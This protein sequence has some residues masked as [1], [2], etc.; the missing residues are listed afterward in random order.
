MTMRPGPSAAR[1]VLLPGMGATAAMYNALRRRLDFPIECIDWPAYR[2]ERSYAEV[3][4]RIV[5]EHDIRDGDV[6]GGSSLG[7]MVA[8]EMAGIVRPA[9]CVLLGSAVHASEVRTLLSILAPLAAVAPVELVQTLAGSRTDLVSA[10][11]SEADTSFIRAM[12]AY[13]PRWQGTQGRTDTLFRLHGRQDPVIPCP[14]AG[15]TVIEGAG[16]VVAMTHPAETA[17]FLREVRAQLLADG[18]D[19]ERNGERSS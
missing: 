9:G 19:G 18:G 7:G 10:M 14:A 16:H 6:V 11:F 3:A 17:A 15:A 12:S 1:W 2:G 5:E 13:L 8:L 4:R